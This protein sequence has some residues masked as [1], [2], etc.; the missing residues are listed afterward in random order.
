M[1]ASR[2]TSSQISSVNPNIGSFSAVSRMSPTQ[3]VQSQLLGAIKRGEYAPG[4][5]LP[6]ERILCESFGVSRVSVREALA[7]LAATGLI[8]VRQGSGAFVRRRVSDEYAGPFAFYIAENQ[9][10]L[11]ELLLVRGALDG[12]A[13]AEA[14]Q[15][16][17]AAGRAALEQAHADFVAAVEAKADPRTLSEVDVRFHQ[18]I[19]HATE[20]TLL[21]QLLEHL[22]SVLVES[23]HILFAQSGQPRRSLKDHAAILDAILR[24]ESG[25]AQRR[26]VQHA[27]KMRVW[28][29]EF[30]VER[31]TA[32]N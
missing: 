5:K 27:D 21:P 19:A 7:G 18:A 25:T 30:A 4:D 6:S 17:T 9:H 20:G 22:N 2:T 11:S 13:A 24:A 23:R 3:Q 28:I 29:D 32:V 14:A 16:L 26:A 10:D 31:S 12:I 15:Q 8:D 1:N